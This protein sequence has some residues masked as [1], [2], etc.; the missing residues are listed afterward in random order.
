MNVTLEE[1]GALAAVVTVVLSPI[2]YGVYRLTDKVDKQLE[3]IGKKLDRVSDMSEKA[4]TIVE[5]CPHCPHREENHR[6]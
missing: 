1:L 2:Y 6:G 5:L 4:L 3:S